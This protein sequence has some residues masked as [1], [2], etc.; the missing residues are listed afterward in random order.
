MLVDAGQVITL[1]VQTKD[2][3]SA[4]GVPVTLLFQKPWAQSAA[5]ALTV[6]DRDAT[7]ATND[8]HAN[9]EIFMPSSLRRGNDTGAMS[10]GVKLRFVQE[11]AEIHD[12]P[13]SHVLACTR[14]AFFPGDTSMTLADLSSI[15]TVIS[16]LAVLVSL[17]YLS[18]Q[19]RQNVR[20]SQALI[21]QGRAAR[22]ADTALRIAELRA[23][24]GI[25]KCFEGAPDVSAQDVARFL[26][27][28]RAVFISA[29]D[30]YFQ[31]LQGLLDADAFKSFETSVRG[32]MGSP[33][34][35]AGWRMTE[36]MYE[37]KFRAF[38]GGLSGDLNP[39]QVS[40]RRGL[41]DWKA[42]LTGASPP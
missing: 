23:A 39:T 35:A 32:G 38:M 8:A 36:D 1:V 28:C 3:L 17:V 27:V 41:A 26:N 7:K 40:R 18:L 13:E 12:R 5:A 42:A 30:S 24:D 4:G 31:N 21:Q 14:V 25:N 19:T 2:E 16:G 33:G 15:A 37:P 34:I 10:S 29:E 11:G 9:D 20:H 6:I 22:I